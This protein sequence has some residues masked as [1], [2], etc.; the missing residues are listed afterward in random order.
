ME[1]FVHNYPDFI[2][3]EKLRFTANNGWPEQENWQNE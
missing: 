3:L 1:R 2:F